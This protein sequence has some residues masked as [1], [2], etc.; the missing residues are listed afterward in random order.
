MKANLRGDGVKNALQPLKKVNDK[1]WNRKNLEDIKSIK[2]KNKQ[3]KELKEIEKD[4][5]FLKNQYKLEQFKNVP[6]KLKQN[7]ENWVSNEKGK[8]KPIQKNSNPRTPLQPPRG[9]SQS[10]PTTSNRPNK[11]IKLGSENIYG[12]ENNGPSSMFD[13]YYS[14]KLRSKSPI[15]DNRDYNDYND[16]NNNYQQEQN[17][18]NYD[19]NNNNLNANANPQD[20]INNE[21]NAYNAQLENEAQNNNNYKEIPENNI[22]NNIN[23]NSNNNNPE[24]EQ[25]IKEYKEKY[26]TDEALENMINEF[27]NKKSVEPIPEENYRN[28]NY[29]QQKKTN[30][31]IINRRR[32]VHK[33]PTP[34]VN[35]APIILPKIHKNY[36]REN[37]QLVKENKV[38]N[39]S[40]INEEKVV[41]KKHKDYGKVPDYIKKYEL[42]REIR[43]EEIKKQEEAAKYPKGTKLLTE[44]ERISTLNGLINSKKEMTNLLE[45]LPITTR[46]LA[47]QNKK[48]ELIR[49]IEEVEKAIEMFSKKQVFIKA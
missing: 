48:E 27:N 25:L 35:D 16:Y 30:T 41:D 4:N 44:E 14:N 31:N 8:H 36:I 6:S 10:K 13:K 18:N 28:G 24:I 2:E 3:N 43:K 46:T 23:N 12:S 22:N 15:Q 17:L 19:Y 29:E 38:P 32:D 33:G 9:K 39:K 42:E 49:K 45:K 5:D 21:I 11:V 20:I 40:K 47:M 37:R 34:T 1:K 7:T 26:G